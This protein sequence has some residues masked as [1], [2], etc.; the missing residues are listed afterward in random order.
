V[1]FASLDFLVFL[2][3]VL[4]AVHLLGHRAQNLALLAAS[5]LFYGYVHP[6]FLYL[7]VG[8]SAANFAG[9]LAIERWPDHRRKILAV[10]VAL[11]LGVLA[12]FKYLDFFIGSVDGL[13]RSF[14]FESALSPFGLFLPVGISFYIFQGIGY[15]VDVFRRDLRARRNFVE[16]A[17]FVSFFPQLVAGPIERAANLLPQIE[18]PRRITALDVQEGLVLLVWGFFKKL[19]VADNTS[20]VVNKIFALEA[21]GFSLLWVGVFAFAVQILADFSGYT[22]IARGAARLLGFRLMRNFELPYL[23]TS[24][25]D[26]WRRWHVSLSSWLRDYLYIPLGGSRT[27]RAKGFRNVTITFLLCGLWHGASWNFVL[28]GAYHGVLIVGERIYKR[29][30][31]P[32]PF[33]RVLVPFK[34]LGMF[35]LTL[36]GWLIFRETN[37]EWLGTYFTLSPFAD[38]S[39]DR[40]IALYFLNLTLLYS[41]P[42]WAH[43]AFAVVAK[44]SRTTA[45]ASLL[46]ALSNARV[47]VAGVLLLLTIVFRNTNPSDF[48]YFQF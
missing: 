21:P 44:R 4:L 27:S 28:W 45:S 15:T 29:L 17:L 26:F 3:A 1:S 46:P 34:V 18:K 23:A 7:I 9:A 41:L 38:T 48:I 37:I 8:V 19:V 47:V 22:D 11:G 43:A 14:G 32:L 16:F 39:A 25:A 31:P 10:T 30:V 42:I 13:L 33:A 2:P 6:W 35:L 20:L 24:P 12:V 36:I 5:Y 40:E